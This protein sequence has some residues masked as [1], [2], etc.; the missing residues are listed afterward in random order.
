MRLWRGDEEVRLEIGEVVGLEG[1]GGDGNVFFFVFCFL[2]ER[3]K[4]GIEGQ[5]REGSGSI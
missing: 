4:K 3:E 5:R 2:G 1:F